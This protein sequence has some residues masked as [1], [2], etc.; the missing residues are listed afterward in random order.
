MKVYLTID[1]GSTYTKLTAIDIDNEVILATS[2]DIT[3]IED[4]I[5]KGYNKA[6]ESLK[7]KISKN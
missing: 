1:F 7:N 4:D 2:K 3:T 5:M 6:F